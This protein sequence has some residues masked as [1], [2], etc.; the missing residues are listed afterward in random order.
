MEPQDTFYI[1]TYGCEMNKSDSID[2]ALSLEA[3]GYRR[4]QDE[5][6]AS[7]IILNTCCVR[8]H[9]EERIFGRLG[10]YRSLKKRISEEPIIVLAGCMAQ[11]LGREFT[12]LFPEVNIIAGTYH[13]L[14]IPRYLKEHERSG[15]KQ[16]FID[17]GGYEFSPYRAMKA[18]RHSA[19][20]NII[21]GCSNF[22][23]YCVVPFVRGPEL[24]KPSDDVID[25][26]KLLAE[27]GVVEITLL[28]QNVNTYGRD[29]G[30]ISFAALLEKL[31]KVG[32]I[33]WIRFLTSHPK[34]FDENTIKSIAACEKVCPEFY[35]PI[36]S[37]SDRILALMN[38][39]Y[40]LA[41]Y[42]KTVSLL[43]KH[44]GDFSIISDIIV[45]FPSET[46]SDFRATLQAVRSVRFDDAFTYRYSPRPHIKA[47][48]LPG[49]VG[50]AIAKQRLERL[51]ALRREVSLQKNRAEIG[52]KRQVLIERV[53]KKN[54][55]EMLA[56]TKKGKPVVVKC[57]RLPGS[58]VYVRIDEISGSTLRAREAREECR[59]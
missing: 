56:K 3:S 2:I 58:F 36:Q 17:K 32:G 1:E 8:Q 34:D 25:E 23:S 4:T 51:I 39:G 46:E 11:L 43:Y 44:I 21:K 14:E 20:V 9:A 26:A 7:V 37:G 50:P 27:Q 41:H 30:D 18:E 42:M 47:E 54:P 53:S 31:D 38:R 28:G 40:T 16:V 6:E 29:N 33:R 5:K 12:E 52:M 24:S 13:A 19:W 35:L 57:D 45:G 10:Y 55:D 59:V 48:E 15:Q 22:C 49:K